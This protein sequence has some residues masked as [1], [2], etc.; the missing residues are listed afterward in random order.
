VTDK[1]IPQ[2]RISPL[3]NDHPMMPWQGAIAI[4]RKGMSWSI[5]RSYDRV[6]YVSLLGD[7]ALAEHIV[8]LLNEDNDKITPP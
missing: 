4:E 7:M 8:R 1:P 5:L 3:P 2:Y 6:V